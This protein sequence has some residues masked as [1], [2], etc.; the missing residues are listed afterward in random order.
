VPAALEAQPQQNPALKNYSFPF[1]SSVGFDVDGDG[2]NDFTFFA[3][4]ASLSGIGGN[5]IF[6]LTGSTVRTYSFNS[7]ITPT[8]TSLGSV[9]LSSMSGQT[10]YIGV[11]FTHASATYTGWVQFDFTS[12]FSHAVIDSAGWDATPGA[13]IAAG[14]AAIPEPAD[15]AAGMGVFALAA[16]WW[17]RRRMDSATI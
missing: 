4:S 15:V 5:Q 11:T 12:G 9:S 16:A 8:D 6:I 3:N 1:A 14:A 10:G 2:T 7:T 13:S 17:R